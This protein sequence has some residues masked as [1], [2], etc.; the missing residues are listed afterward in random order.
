MTRPGPTP[1]P[2]ESLPWMAEAACR[3]K[4][5][6]I[7]FPTRGA[8]TGPAKAICAVCTVRPECRTYALATQQRF[9]IWG[10]LSERERRIER[11]RLRTALGLPYNYPLRR[12]DIGG[13]T[14]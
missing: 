10:G 9:G 3:G 8:D 4:D 13:K 2:F 11:R 5:T 12:V 14:A 6:D 1:I 7:F